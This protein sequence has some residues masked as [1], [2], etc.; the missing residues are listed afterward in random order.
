MR[1]MSPL[2]T[3]AMVSVCAEAVPTRAS[4]KTPAKSGVSLIEILPDAETG[5]CLGYEQMFTNAACE[6]SRLLL[7]F[8]AYVRQ[9]ARR[10]G[11]A[12]LE[13]VLGN[14]VINGAIARIWVRAAAAIGK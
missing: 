9:M 6:S 8:L 2:F 1:I 11:A 13:K 10:P 14:V 3:V 5:I 4:V 7:R 12:G